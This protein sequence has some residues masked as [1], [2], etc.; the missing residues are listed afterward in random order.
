[1]HIVI[2]LFITQKTSIQATKHTRYQSTPSML[3]ILVNVTVFDLQQGIL[4]E[5]FQ[6][7]I[8]ATIFTKVREGNT[9]R[10][11]GYDFRILSITD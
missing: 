9:S 10:Q 7:N 1:M 3:D 4:K 11:G 2:Q 5:F 8:G 6:R